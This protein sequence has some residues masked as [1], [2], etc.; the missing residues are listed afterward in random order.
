MVPLHW[1]KR[2]RAELMHSSSKD[3]LGTSSLGGWPVSPKEMAAALKHRKQEERAAA[4][5]EQA[6]LKRTTAVRS[7]W[8][9][10]CDDS[11]ARRVVCE[12]CRAKC[13]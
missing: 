10:A 12:R 11:V 7:S 4:K 1:W 3:S 6:D 8:A 2:Q 9:Q 13:C 5:Q